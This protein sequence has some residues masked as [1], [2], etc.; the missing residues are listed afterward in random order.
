[1]PRILV[2]RPSPKLE[3]GEI[4]HIE[5]TPVNADLALAQWHDYTDAFRE[6]HWEVVEIAPADTHPDGVFVEDT[7]VMFGD[8]AVLTR[9]GADS[10]RDEIDTTRETLLRL[11]IEFDEITAPATLEGGDVLKV[12]DTVYVGRSSRT[13]A[14]AIQQLRELLEPRRW[15]VIEVPV[16]RCLHLKTGITAL[17]DGT[18]I[19]YPPVVDD[20]GMFENFLAVPEATGTAVV[21]LNEETVLLSSDAPQT[22]A[23]LRARGLTV[24]E[25]PI[26]EFEKLEGCV[27]CLSVRVRD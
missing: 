2:R 14:A 5:R 13:N 23:L 21:V 8:R 6:R 20:P 3:D 16:T 22:A 15:R 18:I 7:V 11:G 27:T 1:M 9:P 24:I 17:P 12:G 26:T 4:T 19:G 25:R 10:R